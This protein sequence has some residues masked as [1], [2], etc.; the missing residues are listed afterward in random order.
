MSTTKKANNAKNSPKAEKENPTTAK[1]ATTSKTQTKSKSSD[2]K[3]KEDEIQEK[4]Y[5]WRGITAKTSKREQQKIRQKIRNKMM[6]LIKQ[7]ESAQA[8]EDQEK[9]EEVLKNLNTFY[10]ENATK[11]DYSLES[12]Y[13]GRDKSKASRI[14]KAMDALKAQYAKSWSMKIPI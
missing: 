13:T 10:L 11:N 4:S 8:D 14:G 1:N 9:A 6:S 12:A 3:K 5:Q 2:A 7:W